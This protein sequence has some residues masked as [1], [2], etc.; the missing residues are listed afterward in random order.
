MSLPIERDGWTSYEGPLN[1]K[2][3]P[4]VDYASN[5]ELSKEQVQTI[6]N[7]LINH[8]GVPPSAISR[9]TGHGNVNQPY[10]DPSSPANRVVIITYTI[11]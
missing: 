4:A 2:G 11:K 8:L 10:P 9:M 3:E 6:A 7:L 5:R 1:A